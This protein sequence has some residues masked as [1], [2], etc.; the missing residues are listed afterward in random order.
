MAKLTRSIN[1][2]FT[3]V[4][5][6][7]ALI[8]CFRESMHRLGLPGRIYAGDV[9]QNASA[10]FVADE[11][12][13]LPRISDPDF[14]DILLDFCRQRHIHLVVPLIDPE[15]VPLSRRRGEFTAIGTKLLVC[16]E[17]ANLISNDKR[18]TE[19]FFRRCGVATPSVFHLEQL[20]RNYDWSKPLLL[21]P[22]R[23][24]SSVGVTK[25]TSLEELR[26]YW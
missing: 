20:E 19:E 21:K 9:K 12:I 26:F 14:V 2:L 24:S 25:I 23:G 15:L 4:G 7:V 18:R 8:R 16:G 3:S 13:A 1:I 10:L 11:K 17:E 6:R 5:R 22:A